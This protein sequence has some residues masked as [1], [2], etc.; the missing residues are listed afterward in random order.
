MSSVPFNMNMVFGEGQAFADLYREFYPRV[1]SLCRRI[2]GSH[3]DAE[4]ASNEVFARL[5][6]AMKTYNRALPFSRWLASVA[7]HYCI[8]LLR[9]RGAEQRVLAPQSVEPAERASGVKSPLEELLEQEQ[10]DAVRAAIARLPERYRA[11]VELRYYGELGYDEIARELG[12]SRANAK[13]LVF[14]ARKEIQW[15]L[16]RMPSSRAGFGG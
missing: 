11:P 4:D 14:R 10:Q 7:S 6:R 1:L 16:E 15:T 9:R 2:L 12:L 8:D 5:P 13:T 3:E